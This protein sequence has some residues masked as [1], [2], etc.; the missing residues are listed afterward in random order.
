[1]FFGLR[2]LVTRAQ[3]NRAQRGLWG[4]KQIQYGNQI[5]FSNKK[6]EESTPFGFALLI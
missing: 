1:M 5:S 2:A 3:P 6:Y 4:G